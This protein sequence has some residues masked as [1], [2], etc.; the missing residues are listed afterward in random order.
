WEKAPRN[1]MSFYEAGSWGPARVENLLALDGA[2]WWAV[3]HDVPQQRTV[4]LTDE[5]EQVL[6]RG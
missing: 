4:M 6:S 2:H 1:T 5:T 3:N